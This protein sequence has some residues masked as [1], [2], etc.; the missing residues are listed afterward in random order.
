VNLTTKRK[1]VF[2][3]LIKNLNDTWRYRIFYPLRN[4]EL[5]THGYPRFKTWKLK[6]PLV[7]EYMI[8]DDHSGTECKICPEGIDECHIIKDQLFKRKIWSN[9][10]QYIK[11]EYI[12]EDRLFNPVE[13]YYASCGDEGGMYFGSNA[14]WEEVEKGGVDY[15]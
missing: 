11:T 4:F 14:G 13:K 5:K 8:R 3:S 10:I 1:S 12:C 2:G 15:E 6:D 7:I 9:Q